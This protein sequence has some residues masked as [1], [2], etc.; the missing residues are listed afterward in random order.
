MLIRSRTVFASL[1]CWGLVAFISNVAQ[2]ADDYRL[3]DSKGQHLEIVTPAGKPILRYMYAHDTSSPEI[4]FNTAKVFAHV[5]A[6]DGE[7]TLTKG[8]GG[9]YPHHRGIFIGWSKMEHGGAKHD[10][11]HVRNTTQKH[12]KFLNTKPTVEGASI[13]SIIHW[14]GTKGE[15]VLEEERTYSVRARDDAHAEIDFTSELRAVNGD[16]K[17]NGDP[18]HAGIQ[19]R[20]S[21]KV[22]VNGSAKYTFHEAG[23][24]PKKQLDL[25][26]V[27]ATFTIGDQQWTAQHMSHQKNPKG[28]RWSAY[29]D[30]GRFGPFTVAE[31]PDGESLTF[32]Y[33]FRI[34]AGGVPERE[35]LAG[36][37][38]R[39][40]EGN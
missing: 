18:E 31:I 21:Q 14:I 7:A 25:P 33:R 22:A 37:Y 12:Q 8:A 1:A 30:Y 5:M 28:A 23:I 6:P 29:R 20:P 36:H 10:L 26:W 16:V 13:K 11:W 15:I 27:A 2:A 3:V 9:K 4:K 17:L 19:F 39:Y 38:Q 40:S 34:T 32:R 35:N 24:D